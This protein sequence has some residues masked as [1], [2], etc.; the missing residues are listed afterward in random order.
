MKAYSIFF[1]AETYRVSLAVTRFLKF[2]KFLNPSS[3]EVVIV[4]TPLQ[5]KK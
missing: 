3:F 5:S 1:E 2:L 4:L